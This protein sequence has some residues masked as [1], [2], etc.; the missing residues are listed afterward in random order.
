MRNVMQGVRVLEVAAWT[1]VPAAGAVLADWGADVIKIEHPNGGDPQRAL[2]SSGL[3]PGGPNAVN[4]IIEQPNRGKR[5]IG[6]DIST[7][8]GREVLYKIAATSDVFL[9]S[10]LP[11][12]RQKLQIDV[13]HIRAINPDIIYVRGSGQGALGPEADRGGLDGASYWA[14]G[15][16]ANALTPSEVEWPISPRPAF[17]DLPGGMTIAGG[18]AA[19]LFGRERSGEAPIVDVSLLGFAMW[20]LSPDI[21]ATKVF[22][23]DPLAQMRGPR[24]QNP[25]P[26]VGQYKTKDERFLYL[27]M[28]QPD[29]FW[30]E[31]CER[32]GRPDLIDDPRFSTGL[33]RYENREECIRTFDEIIGSRTLAEWREAFQGM[34]G[35]WAPVQTAIELYD[36][37][38]VEPNGYIVDVHRD[39]GV[40]FPLVPNPVMFDEERYSLTAA[41]EHGQHT[42]ELLL[43]LGYTW[44]DIAAYKGSGAVL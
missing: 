37:P 9:T 8:E 2:I 1:F 6:L 3:L 28:L 4:Y 19:A 44:E 22:G 21:V 40:D 15:G 31:A 17:G 30:P 27:M 43:E 18:I 34:K 41:P 39:D 32:L 25:N 24:T 33:A 16:I 11:S 10:F 13:E 5:S 26:L 42:E 12:V 29:R 38:Q 7:D 36:Y 20:T 35:V 23:K 14:R